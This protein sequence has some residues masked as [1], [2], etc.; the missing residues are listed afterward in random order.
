VRVRGRTVGVAGVKGFG[1]GFQGRSGAEFGEPEMKAFMAHSRERADAL[2]M[3]LEG[4]EGRCDVRIALTHYAPVPDTVAGEP[5]EIHA[6]L[7]SYLLAEAIDRGGAALAVHG[8]AHAG[9][10][11][12]V[13]A[14]GV[15]VRNVARPLIRSPYRIY[16]LLEDQLPV[17]GRT[18]RS[19]TVVQGAASRAAR[20]PASSA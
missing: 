13:T 4:L 14:G 1:G 7:G 3:A 12:G 15:R 10:E 8:H 20:S 6:W 2:R 11:K 17:G 5:P 16:H 9:T 18:A 19:G